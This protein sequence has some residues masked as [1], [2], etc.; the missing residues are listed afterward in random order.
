MVTLTFRELRQGDGDAVE[1]VA[2]GSVMVDGK[3]AVVVEGD[4]PFLGDVAR[5]LVAEPDPEAT[6]RGLPAMFKSA[7]LRASL[8]ED[9]LGVNWCNQ[10]GGDTCSTGGGGNGDRGEVKVQQANPQQTAKAIEAIFPGKGVTVEQVARMAGALPGATV[11]MTTTT[12]G[13]VQM[14]ID[15]PRY[16]ASRVLQFEG[17][18]NMPVMYNV[19]IVSKGGGG[20]GV[21]IDVF[22]QQVQ[23]L[24][25]AGV[26][27][28]KTNAARDD[29][30][31]YVGYKIWPKFGYDGK[32]PEA[33]T[34][35][36][37]FGL[38]GGLP[39]AL[40]GAKTVQDLYRLPGGQQWWEKHGTSFDGTFDLSAGSRSRGVFERY[41]A[42]KAAERGKGVANMAT[43]AGPGG[44]EEIGDLGAEDNRILAEVWEELNREWAEAEGRDPAEP[45][46]PPPAEEGKAGE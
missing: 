41:A 9:A 4:D 30:K 25:A 15:H 3:E 16:T 29:S 18:E 19:E 45:L 32:I 7:Y 35:G 1:D 46:G 8:A 13:A 27:K 37:F 38:V 24:S 17:R 23:E 39:K 36:S 11:R 12:G 10:H 14:V 42:K 34:G 21:G 5:S 43:N 28:I 33:L 22:G 2:L 20:G 31:P 6:A 40:R 26:G 44:A